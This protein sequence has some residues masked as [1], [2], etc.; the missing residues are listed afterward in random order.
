[1]K[2]Q[3]DTK[4]KTIG[5]VEDVSIQELN[6]FI[7]LAIPESEYENWKIKTIREIIQSP[8]IIIEKWREK[9]WNDY[10]PWWENPHPQLPK[11]WYGTTNP[12][13]GNEL[14]SPQFNNT[15]FMVELK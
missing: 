12:W 14:I 13:N 2:L 11:I 3:I 15:C 6:D 7:R 9:Q 1:M 10:H 8:P 4:E 5:I